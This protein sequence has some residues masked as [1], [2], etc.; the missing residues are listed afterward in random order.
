MYKK[1][2]KK[3]GREEEENEQM[4]ISPFFKLHSQRCLDIITF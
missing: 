2:R 3:E 4:S 1:E